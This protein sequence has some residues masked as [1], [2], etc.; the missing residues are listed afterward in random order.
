LPQPIV[1]VLRDG[2]RLRS[3]ESPGDDVGIESGE[4]RKEGGTEL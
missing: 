1:H 2:D 4:Q 3:G